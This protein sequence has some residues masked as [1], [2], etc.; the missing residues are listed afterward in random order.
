[1]LDNDFLNRDH[2]AKIVFITLLL[3]VDRKTG[4][5]EGGRF[6]L[7]EHCGLKP[8]TSYA[9]SMRLVKAKMMTLSSNNKY[10]TY[11][12][13]NWL[14]YQGNDDNNDDNKM[15][16]TRQQNDTLTRSKE[17]KNKRNKERKDFEETSRNAYYREWCF[18][19]RSLPFKVWLDKY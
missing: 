7:A 18:T 8:T 9:A 3:L 15:T 14:K 1:M 2:T 6:Q 12:V 10:S 4:V 11:S 5:W 16:T 13:S 19:D 17:I